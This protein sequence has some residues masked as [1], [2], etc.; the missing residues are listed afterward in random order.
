MIYM[1]TIRLAINTHSTPATGCTACM[2]GRP[3]GWTKAAQPYVAPC[4][5]GSFGTTQWLHGM[6]QM[7]HLNCLWLMATYKRWP[8]EADP[9]MEPPCAPPGPTPNPQ[10]QARHVVMQRRAVC[11]CMALAEQSVDAGTR[12]SCHFG[13]ATPAD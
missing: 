13:A 12:H 3:L 11:L 8:S 6:L 1:H 9:H 4:R 5:S 2:C 7:L 10:P